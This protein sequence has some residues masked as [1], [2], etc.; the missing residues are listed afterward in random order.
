MIA[1]SGTKTLAIDQ[2]IQ[3]VNGVVTH[4]EISILPGWIVW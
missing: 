1:F 2:T 3:T 4:C